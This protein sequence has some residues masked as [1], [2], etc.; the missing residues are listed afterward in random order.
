[1]KNGVELINMNK[2][3]LLT[4]LFAITVLIGTAVA[5]FLAK[6]YRFSTK[7]GT[8]AGTGIISITSI[9]DQASV[10]LDGH[11]TTATNTNIN[12]LLPKDYDVKIQKDGFIPWE[13][14]VTVKEGLVSQIKATLF[15]AIPTVY[16]LTFNGVFNLSQSP[17]GQRLE[18]MVPASA[19]AQSDVTG[20]KKSGIWVWDMT[21]S[22]PLNFVGGREP[23]RVADFIPG[24]DYQ[25]AGIR[26]S[27]DSTQIMVNL[28]DRSLLLDASNFN[29]PARDITA[30]LQSTVDTWNSQE[31]TKTDTELLTIKDPTA[32]SE[33]SSSALM[34][35]SPDQTKVLESKDG[36]TN[37][38]V[39]D[40]VDGSSYSIPQANKII[41]L[42]DSR[43][44]IM[45]EQLG[46]K[47]DS[48]GFYSGKVSVVEFDGTN[49]D[50]V[51]VGNFDTS[52]VY[53]WPDLSRLAL[54]SSV[55]TSTANIPNLFGVNLK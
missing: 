23:H 16:P 46:T 8:L 43:H 50:D 33:A 52:T 44:L 5:I 24:L 37:F 45:V 15:P 30:V 54:V 4:L 34:K 7:T 55:A 21:S 1:M 20:I 53:P 11:L 26:W 12:S 49:K 38:K 42:P 10:Y 9:P 47:A 40:L 36:K 22:S 14:K 29:N 31:K 39:L 35:F 17:D 6:G 25:S 28:T 51:Y 19:D 32:R 48:N 2:R 41:W 3:V 13:K 27:P 18:F